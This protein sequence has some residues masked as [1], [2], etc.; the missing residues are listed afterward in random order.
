MNAAPNLVGGVG[1]VL[2]CGFLCE[3]VSESKHEVAFRFS[4][5]FFLDIGGALTDFS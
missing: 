2:G 1:C 4:V 5:G 3:E